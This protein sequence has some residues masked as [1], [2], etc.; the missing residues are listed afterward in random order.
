MFREYL[1]DSSTEAIGFVRCEV[2]D[3]ESCRSKT[4]VYEVLN[5]PE[6]SI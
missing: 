4:T 6:V 5:R 2:E 3:I 1:V